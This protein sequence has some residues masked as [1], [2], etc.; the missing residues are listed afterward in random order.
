MR[1]TLNFLILFAALLFNSAQAKTTIVSGLDNPWAFA[2]LPN[3]D[4]LITEREGRL[5]IVENGQ[6]LEQPIAGTPAAFYAGQGGLLDVMLDQNFVDNQR[7]YLS[8]AWGGRKANALQ[9]MAAKLDGMQL[10]EQQV[11]FTAS[12]LK[13]TSHHYAGRLLQLADGTLLATVGDGFDYREQ[14]QTLD[15]HFGKVI[16]I[17]TDGTVPTDNPFYEREDALPEIWSYGHRNHQ[18]L[19]LVGEQVFENEHGPRGGDEVNLLKAGSNYGWPV[20][21]QGIDYNGAQITPFK[22][23]AG[24]E[25]PLIDWTPSIAPSS[26][27]Y[28][29]G[30]LYVTSLAE[31]RI[32]RLQLNDN[33]IVDLGPVYPEIDE[34]LRD[35]VSG[36]DDQLY[37]LTDGG[38]A[39]IIRLE[40]SDS[41]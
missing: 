36:P 15:N 30:E 35:I 17:N 8:Y 6:L 23:Y 5:R 37:V 25:Q 20:I 22:E 18:A 31:G 11:L 1:K 12:P 10:R 41:N 24:M 21:T 3:G 7:L 29:K 38:N 14:A 2:F 32:R 26:M 19:T 4:M 34:R 13:N 27:A 40:D 9:I 28:H 39:S 16:R 33:K